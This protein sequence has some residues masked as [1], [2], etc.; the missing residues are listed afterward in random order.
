MPKITAVAVAL[1]Y[2]LLGLTLLIFVF[3]LLSGAEEFGGGLQGIVQNSPNALPWLG[4][5]VVNF[6]VFKWQK[7]GGVLLTIF[8][9]GTIFFF[10]TWQH[11]VTFLLLSLPL[12]VM[13]IF[14]MMA[15]QK[16]SK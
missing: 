5:L 14:F 15:E 13:G 1:K 6:V 8:G 9:V 16:D 12:L 4:L 7:I 10:N 11:P 3:A 2:L